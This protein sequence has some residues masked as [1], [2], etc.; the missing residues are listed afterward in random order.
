M[1]KE[2]VGQVVKTEAVISSIEAGV[3]EESLNF[4][5]LSIPCADTAKV[6]QMI[7]EKSQILLLI[8]LQTENNQFPAIEGKC[9]LANYRVNQKCDK[10]NIKH[11]RLSTD[12]VGQLAG[13][14]RAKEMLNITFTEIN[15]GLPFDSKEAETN[16][17]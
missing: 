12:Q 6:T 17:D 14:A 2:K 7:H 10:P 11:L 9:M 13:Y 5:T 15:P 3:H 4:G 8:E 16:E 1:A